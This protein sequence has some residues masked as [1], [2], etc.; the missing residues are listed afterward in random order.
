[1]STERDPLGLPRM[2]EARMRRLA[3]LAAPV[4]LAWLRNRFPDSTWLV[5]V[6]EVG[7]VGEGAH[8]ISLPALARNV[9]RVLVAPDDADTGG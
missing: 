4:Y 5:H 7:E 9:H 2:S 8:D 1:M 3:R 6:R